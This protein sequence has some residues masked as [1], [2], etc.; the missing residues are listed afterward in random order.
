MS[1]RQTT[2]FGRVG[3]SKSSPLQPIELFHEID[4]RPGYYAGVE[5]R[6]F[7]RV[8]IRALHY[9][10]RA[11]PAAFDRAT[12]AQQ[13]LIKQGKVDI[14]FDTATDSAVRLG[15]A[16]GWFEG[17]KAR[18]DLYSVVEGRFRGGNQLLEVPLVPWWREG[19]DELG[20]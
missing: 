11:D 13:E 14:G 10:N 19:A 2:L 7:D 20:G 9:D 8:V 12:P 16:I 1:D 3:S 4:G 15:D 17:F 5:G 6:N 18:S